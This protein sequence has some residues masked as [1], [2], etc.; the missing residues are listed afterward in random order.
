M[1]IED[2]LIAGA[3]ATWNAQLERANK[4]F[5]VLDAHQLESQVA[6]GRN[7]LIYLWG[8][9]TAIHDRM[10]PL[11]GIG[12]RVHPEFDAIFLTSP[13]R[14]HPLPSRDTILDWWNT[15]NHNLNTGMQAFTPGEWLEKHSAVS[16]E[17]FAKDP[18][19][20]RFSILLS[21]SHHLAYHFGQTVLADK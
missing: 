8:H 6:P 1:P 10:L 18:L 7:R 15:V 20:N 9:L 11:L 14:A 2:T 5:V 13:D 4:L 19:R 3:L 12:E 17:E 21:R 16:D